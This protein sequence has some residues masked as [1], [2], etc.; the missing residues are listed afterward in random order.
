MSASASAI[1]KVNIW[2][3]VIDWCEHTG[4]QC[5]ASSASSE[6]IAIWA[7]IGQRRRW[8]CDLTKVT[9]WGALTLRRRT[10]W[11]TV[12]GE[13]SLW[14]QVNETISPTRPGEFRGRWGSLSVH[15]SVKKQS[16]DVRGARFDRYLVAVED[17]NL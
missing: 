7:A 1:P 15:G 16:T 11:C 6:E 8:K 4:E 3:R 13:V 9:G 17:R 5:G 12:L 14:R 10:G 2:F